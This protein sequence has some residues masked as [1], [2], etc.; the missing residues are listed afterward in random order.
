[1]HK[2][3]FSPLSTNTG[4]Q[5]CLDLSKQLLH[6]IFEA[7]FNGGIYLI[8]LQT[9]NTFKVI[10][11]DEASLNGQCH[12]IIFLRVFFSSNN[13]SRSLDMPGNYIRF[14]RI[15]MSYRGRES[16]NSFL[17]NVVYTFADKYLRIQAWWKALFLSLDRALNYCKNVQ[18]LF[19]YLGLKS[20]KKYGRFFPHSPS[21]S[22]LN[23]IIWFY[24][25]K[26]VSQNCLNPNFYAWKSHFVNP[27]PH[28][29]W[30]AAQPTARG[31]IGTL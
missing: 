29:P 22:V 19:P 26:S 7:E 10:L 17:K 27:F 2:K 14:S 28:S 20:L 24:I 9:W 15:F 6:L 8:S 13:F 23:F 12:E 25:H 1:M 11:T 18:T 16:I 31:L 30:E 4:D 21:K 5:Y 3:E